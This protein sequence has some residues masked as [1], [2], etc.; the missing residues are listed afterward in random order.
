MVVVARHEDEEQ[1]DFRALTDE[2]HIVNVNELCAER[3]IM[4]TSFSLTIAQTNRV[5]KYRCCFITLLLLEPQ[6]GSHFP[7]PPVGICQENE[8]LSDKSTCPE[9]SLLSQVIAGP[10]SNVDQ[11]LRCTLHWRKKNLEFWPRF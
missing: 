3:C 10:C 4:F 8:H 9:S 2:F 5:S 1:R 6:Q 11:N 7:S